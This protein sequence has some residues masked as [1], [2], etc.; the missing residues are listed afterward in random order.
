MNRSR[1]LKAKKPK[2]AAM[3]P[4][5]CPHFTEDQGESVALKP[6]YVS[7]TAHKALTVM[8]QRSA[9]ATAIALPHMPCAHELGLKSA[10]YW[11]TRTFNQH[12]EPT[13][14]Q[15]LSPS[16]LPPQPS[17]LSPPPQHSG[18]RPQ[19]SAFDPMHTLLPCTQTKKPSCSQGSKALSRA[20]KNRL[21][22][23]SLCAQRLRRRAT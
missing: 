3:N 8:Q 9:T 14:G 1:K 6:P 11:F 17:A 18:F 10:P 22:T 20:E 23:V 15:L 19:T 5:P 2:A 7:A 12:L 16:S 13:V 4:Q 21:G